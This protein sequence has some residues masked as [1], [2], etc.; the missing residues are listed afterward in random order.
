MSKEK[1]STLIKT[2]KFHPPITKK[3][4]ESSK[5]NLVGGYS[6]QIKL[7]FSDRKGLTLANSNQINPISRKVVILFLRL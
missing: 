3:D 1:N 2:Q 7:P 4:L 6:Q 5:I